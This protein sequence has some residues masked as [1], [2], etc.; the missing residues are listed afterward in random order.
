VKGKGKAGPVTVKGKGKAGPVAVKGKGKAG[1]VTVKQVWARGK[2][3]LPARGVPKSGPAGHAPTAKRAS[4]NPRNQPRLNGHPSG[5]AQRKQSSAA[6]NVSEL[7]VPK[8]FLA[9]IREME[10]RRGSRKGTRS[11]S[12]S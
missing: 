8:E 7:T 11:W 9:G 3:P 5:T 2:R 6:R 12:S 4:A 1:P 10:R